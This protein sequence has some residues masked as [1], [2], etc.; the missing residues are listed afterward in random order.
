MIVCNC[1]HFF[2]YYEGYDHGEHDR[3]RSTKVEDFKPTSVPWELMLRA[4]PHGKQQRLKSALQMERMKEHKKW[5]VAIEITGFHRLPSRFSYFICMLSSLLWPKRQCS[6]LCI[7]FFLL[8]WPSLASIRSGIWSI[9]FF[10][11]LS[12]LWS[13]HAGGKKSWSFFSSA[14]FWMILL[15]LLKSNADNGEDIAFDWKAGRQCRRWSRD[16][17]QWR[18][19]EDNGLGIFLCSPLHGITQVF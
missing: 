13:V 14:C 12:W 2:A 15:G 5:D 19:N 3:M 6:D 11:C 1:W 4:S 16:Q 10:C 18:F 17:I 9:C 8:V 7:F